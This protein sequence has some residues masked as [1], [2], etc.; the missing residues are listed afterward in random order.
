MNAISSAV[1]DYILHAT[2]SAQIPR[3]DL[4]AE[5]FA[6]DQRIDPMI[7]CATLAVQGTR[8][9]GIEKFARKISVCCSGKGA[10]R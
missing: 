8:E 10:C 2:P 7:F 1:V 3:E 5:R 9:N 6:D 4:R